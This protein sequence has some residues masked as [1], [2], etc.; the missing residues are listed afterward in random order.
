MCKEGHGEWHSRGHQGPHA[1]IALE[2]VSREQSRDMRR[3]GA[4]PV[5]L[6]RVGLTPRASRY[7]ASV[8]LRCALRRTNAMLSLIHI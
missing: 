1:T 6:R 8:S 2:G 4:R 3:T 7:A 5:G